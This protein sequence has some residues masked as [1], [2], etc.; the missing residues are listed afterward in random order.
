MIVVVFLDFC[1]FH[2]FEGIDFEHD[3]SFFKFQSKI[4]KKGFVESLGFLFLRKTFH[5][6]LFNLSFPSI[7]FLDIDKIETWKNMI[8]TKFQ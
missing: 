5:F 4:F 7:T 3:I 8:K 2:K 6:E 1:Y